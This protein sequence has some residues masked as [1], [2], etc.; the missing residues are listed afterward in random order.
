MHVQVLH[1]SHCPS[2]VEAGTRLTNALESAGFPGNVEFHLIETPEDAAAVPF[3]GS[4]TILL[5]GVDAFPGADRTT[6]LACRIYRTESGLAG[7]PSSEQIAA[8]ITQHQA[9]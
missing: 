6:E 9:Q 2:W 3:S 7:L 1:I 8:A 4:P 5:D